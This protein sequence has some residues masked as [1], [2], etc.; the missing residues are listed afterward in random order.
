MQRRSRSRMSPAM[1]DTIG[2]RAPSVE[3]ADRVL[4][5]DALE[6]VR[7]LHERFDGR[8][9]ELLAARE[10]RQRRI[11]VGETPGFLEE[12][13]KVRESEWRVAPAPS[14][15]DRRTVEITGP[16]DRMVLINALYSGEHDL[17]ADYAGTLLTTCDLDDVHMTNRT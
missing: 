9:R 8:R 5:P 2:I 7:K 15:L 11:D 3:G 10:A 14:D 13:R 16:V 6:F 4:T 12:T 17:L 1:A